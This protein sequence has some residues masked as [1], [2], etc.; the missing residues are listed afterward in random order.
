MNH[1]GQLNVL[2]SKIL[3]MKLDDSVLVQGQH[4]GIP[5]LSV[6]TSSK[7]LSEEGEHVLSSL[8]HHAL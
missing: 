6:R 2:V 8:L 4:M 7:A 3:V 5:G 1:T